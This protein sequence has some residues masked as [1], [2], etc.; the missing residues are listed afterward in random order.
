MYEKKGWISLLF[1]GVW[2]VAGALI[3]YAVFSILAAY[4]FKWGWNYAIPYLFEGTKTIEWTHAW[5]MC[6]LLA[7]LSRHNT[8][9]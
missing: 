1:G 2:K 5:C 6:F 9:S 8:S 4:P 3:L 7:Y